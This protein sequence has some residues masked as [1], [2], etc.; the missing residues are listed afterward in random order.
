MLH[1]I[2][3]TFFNLKN[4]EKTLKQQIL[5]TLHT[6]LHQNYFQ[7]NN[8]FYKPQADVRMGSP[9]SGLMAEIFVQ[10]YENLIII[11]VVENKH[12]IFYTSYIDVTAVINDH[13]KVTSEQ[14]L[15]YTNSLHTNLQCKPTHK[16]NTT[17]HFLDLLICRN[18]Q[19]LVT[20]IYRKSTSTDITLHM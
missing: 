2:M 20:N 19:G 9:I 7:F 18:G 4:T 12:I 11:H 6:F 15:T 8:S 5:Q 16:I 14:I 10:C 3:K 17:V 13:I 1:H